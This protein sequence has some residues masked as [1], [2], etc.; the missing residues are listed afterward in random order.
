MARRAGSQGEKTEAAIRDAALKLIAR[1]GYEAL[2]M[3]RLAEEVG[4]G[5]AAIY[6]YFP[7]KQAILM[8]LL[9]RHMLD[10][11]T[12]WEQARLPAARPA[13]ERLECFTR[14]HIRHHLPRA[15]GVFLSYMELRSLTPD[16]FDRI[17]G[18]RR[19][20]ESD[21]AAILE[22]GR[23]EGSL[24]APAPRVTARAV[25]AML[26]GLTTWYRKSGPLTPSEVEAIY[27]RL[28]AGMVGLAPQERASGPETTSAPA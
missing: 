6:R 23:R 10:L 26:T 11:L 4:L 13:P 27:W 3:R 24:A 20:Y 25:I 18:L 14:F 15:E 22:A 16:N 19:S 12:S 7:N 5:A 2:S 1:C 8:G 17:E 28:V 9:E 21:L